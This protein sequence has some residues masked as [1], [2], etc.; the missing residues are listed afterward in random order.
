M[1]LLP[2][3]FNYLI[4]NGLHIANKVRSWGRFNTENTEFNTSCTEF[5]SLW[6]SCGFLCALCVKMYSFSSGPP[7]ELLFMLG[8]TMFDRPFSQIKPPFQLF[9]VYL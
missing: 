1:S 3:Q 4:V 9:A 2:L 7:S 6:R 8:F 5:S